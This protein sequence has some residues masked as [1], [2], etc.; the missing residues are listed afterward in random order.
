MSRTD[1]SERALTMTHHVQEGYWA[2]EKAAITRRAADLRSWLYQRPEAQVGRPT[3]SV[4]GDK[5]LTVQV[6]VVTHGAFAHFLTEDWDVED[7]M[8]GTAYKNCTSI[9][10]VA[11]TVYCLV[12]TKDRRTSRVCFHARLGGRGGAS[13]GDVG[14]QA[15]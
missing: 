10:T 5:R 6:L 1:V 2:Y 13:G 11:S 7:P 3:P 14:E 12:L 4:V 9:A 15:T 8:L